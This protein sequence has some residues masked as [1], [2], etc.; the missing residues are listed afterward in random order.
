MVLL[1]EELSDRLGPW[2]GDEPGLPLADERPR[3]VFERERH[4]RVRAQ[5]ASLHAVGGNAGVEIHPVPDEPDRDE[6]GATVGTNGRD[7]DV[8]RRGEP[9]VTR[10]GLGLGLR[11]AVRSKRWRD[12]FCWLR[13]PRA[14]RGPTFN[15]R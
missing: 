6:V 1:R 7:T 11:H 9:L 5:V 14:P 3:A 8:A 2:R 15:L 13:R 4:I 12:S 10:L